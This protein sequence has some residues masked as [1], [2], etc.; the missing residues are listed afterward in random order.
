VPPLIQ[1][2]AKSCLTDIT[3]RPGLTVVVHAKVNEGEVDRYLHML[4]ILMW[5]V[6]LDE[7]YH[8]TTTATELAQVNDE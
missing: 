7:T 8:K 5:S 3:C 2:P 4:A 6:R 1:V